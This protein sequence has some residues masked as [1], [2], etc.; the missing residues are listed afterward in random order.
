MVYHTGFDR[1]SNNRGQTSC[2]QAVVQVCVHV[3]PVPIE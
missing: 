3:K 2:V 1:L